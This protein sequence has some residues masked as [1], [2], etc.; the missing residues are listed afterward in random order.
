MEMEL[1][2]TQ[3][4]GFA[5]RRKWKSVQH[6]SSMYWLCS[7]DLFM[8]VLAVYDVTTTRFTILAF[9]QAL[10]TFNVFEV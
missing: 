8:E 3:V 4:E 5:V 6:D 1:Y 2:L 7:I 10:W 9:V